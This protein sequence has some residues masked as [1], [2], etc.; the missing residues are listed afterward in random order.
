MSN[1]SQPQWI[2]STSNLIRSL[3][4]RDPGEDPDPDF[5]AAASKAATLF[6]PG[7]NSVWGRSDL[8]PHKVRKPRKN[9]EGGASGANPPKRQQKLLSWTTQLHCLLVHTLFL[10]TGKFS[11]PPFTFS[12]C[13]TKTDKDRV[14]CVLS[15]AEPL[16]QRVCLYVILMLSQNWE[17]FN[18]AKILHARKYKVSFLYFQLS[19]LKWEE[20]WVLRRL[21]CFFP[22]KQ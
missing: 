22:M 2:C 3:G 10:Q 7:Q 18:V 1:H 9:P 17:L 15:G 5:M 16:N 12:W 19:L 6:T 20:K 4:R 11:S 8:N 14:I 13:Q 21:P